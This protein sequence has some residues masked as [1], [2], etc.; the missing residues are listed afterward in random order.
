MKL[1]RTAYILLIV[2]VAFVGYTFVLGD[3]GFLASSNL[4]S[5]LQQ[6]QSEIRSLKEEN[7]KLEA[8]HDHLKGSSP[9]HLKQAVIIKFDEGTSRHRKV[10][11]DQDIRSVFLFVM[12]FFALLG[13]M[14]MPGRKRDKTLHP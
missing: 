3:R 14:L 4:E 8:R 10:Q 5:Q 9:V 1:M 13:W 6:T 12:I 7:L 2:F 11:D